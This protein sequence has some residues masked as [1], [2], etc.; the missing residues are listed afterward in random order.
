MDDSDR[1]KTL[2]EEVNTDMVET[3][4]ELEVEPKVVA[5]ILQYHDKTFM[6]KELLLMDKQRV[7]S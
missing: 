4:K 6:D 7:V 3:A 1:F 2:A 5:E